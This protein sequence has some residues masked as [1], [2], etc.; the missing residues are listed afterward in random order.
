[1]A[2]PAWR[3]S[4]KAP[5]LWGFSAAIG[6]GFLLLGQM[7][8]AGLSGD[9]ATWPHIAALVATLVLAPLH[10]IGVPLWRYHVHRWEISDEAVY[11]R[12][13]WFVQERRIAPISRV[14]TVDTTRG[15]IDRLLGLST[16]TVTTASSAGAVTITALDEDVADRTVRE[17]TDIA[18]RTRGDAT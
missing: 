12:Q 10:I 14:Q 18:A 15:P 9:P 5:L 8:W 2:D 7:I 16:V 3:P 13:G 11:T 4:K 17:L 1:M 6:W